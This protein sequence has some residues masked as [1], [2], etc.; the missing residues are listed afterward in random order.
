M[1]DREYLYGLLVES[2]EHKVRKLMCDCSSDVRL[3]FLIQK[4][5][6]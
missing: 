1:D 3:Y 4:W 2:I 5:I 6:W